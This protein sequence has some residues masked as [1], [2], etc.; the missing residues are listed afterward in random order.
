M[1]K[2]SQPKNPAGPGAGSSVDTA[3]AVIHVPS[4]ASRV[5]HEENSSAET[6]LSPEERPKVTC[7]GV[8]VTIVNVKLE[9]DYSPTPTPKLYH[10]LQNPLNNQSSAL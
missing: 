8:K 3:H 4:V 10:Y 7:S 2:E 9:K 6:F 1:E 5:S